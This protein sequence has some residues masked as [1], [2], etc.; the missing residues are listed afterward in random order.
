MALTHALQVASAAQHLPAGPAQLFDLGGGGGGITCFLPMAR[1]P[2]M[3][4]FRQ[5]QRD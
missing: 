2:Y 3:R 5:G 1:P 4:R